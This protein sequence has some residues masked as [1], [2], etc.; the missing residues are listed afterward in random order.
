[1]S[2]DNAGPLYHAYTVVK[3]EGA[4]DWW[5]N[6]G[7]AFSH[8]DGKGLNLVLQALPLDG[9]IVL[10]PPK[11]E[12]EE[13]TERGTERNEPDSRFRSGSRQRTQRR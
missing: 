6:I 10:R 2:K 1:M 8:A 12:A 4:D 9:K 3:R 11:A 13:H 7:A 5:C